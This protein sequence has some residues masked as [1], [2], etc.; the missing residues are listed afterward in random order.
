MRKEKMWV[1]WV[2]ETGRIRARALPQIVSPEMIAR[3]VQ[4]NHSADCMAF[5]SAPK[6]EVA[7]QKGRIYL[8]ASTLEWYPLKMKR[9]RSWHPVEMN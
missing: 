3:L 2:D 8:G 7:L 4:L 5:L 1:A 9:R 6:K